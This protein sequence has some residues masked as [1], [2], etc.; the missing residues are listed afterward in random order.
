MSTRKNKSSPNQ[1][2]HIKIMFLNHLL[3]D[4]EESLEKPVAV[5][6]EDFNVEQLANSKKFGNFVLGLEMSAELFSKEKWGVAQYSVQLCYVK[7]LVTHRLF[8]GY[9]LKQ[10]TAEPNPRVAADDR[11]CNTIMIKEHDGSSENQRKSTAAMDIR[12]LCFL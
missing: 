8:Q 3:C 5:T 11:P 12:E 1:V 9:C 2:R 7:S 4:Q 10:L 6:E